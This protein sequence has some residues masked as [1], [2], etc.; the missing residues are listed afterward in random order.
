MGVKA[1]KI[2]DNF[3]PEKLAA[4]ASG[5]IG[6]DIQTLLLEKVSKTKEFLEKFQTAID[7]LVHCCTP[8]LCWLEAETGYRVATPYMRQ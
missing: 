2:S 6:K 7:P 8:S 3:F 4:T 1:R 5:C